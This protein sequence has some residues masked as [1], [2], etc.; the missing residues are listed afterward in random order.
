MGAYFYFQ[1]SE[2]RR[3]SNA[4]PL[5]VFETVGTLPSGKQLIRYIVPYKGR[6]HYVYVTNDTVTINKRTINGKTTNM[7]SETFVK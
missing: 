6:F 3:I 1:G 4:Y 5:S 2:Y 7:E